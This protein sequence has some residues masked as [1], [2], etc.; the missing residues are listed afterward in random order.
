[1]TKT[2]L[3]YLKDV[4]WLD[5]VEE[6]WVE[7]F[8]KKMDAWLKKLVPI[9]KIAR[10]LNTSYVNFGNDGYAKPGVDYIVDLEDAD[11]NM[12]EEN[13][14]V[15]M[16]L[17]EEC[18]ECG[19]AVPYGLAINSSK[20]RSEL[21]WR[22]F[23]GSNPQKYFD[24]EGNVLLIPYFD[25]RFN[26]SELYSSV[27]DNINREFQRITGDKYVEIHIEDSCMYS[28]YLY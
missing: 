10:R 8:E 9:H 22:N 5:L 23:F 1:M 17:E 12:F 24:Q 14:V 6:A 11:N 7:H 28:L 15:Y 4:P 20:D 3:K 26:T 27:I 25:E 21:S 2:K 16:I 13:G 18:P 19:E